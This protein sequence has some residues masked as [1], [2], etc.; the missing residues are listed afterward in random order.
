MAHEDAPWQ[1][2]NHS[3]TPNVRLSHPAVASADGPAPLI[4]V[5]AAIDLEPETPLTID[6]TLSEWDMQSSFICSESGREVRGF[7]HL[8]EAEQDASLK[9]A[10]PHIPKLVFAAFIRPVVA[11][12][13]RDGSCGG[14]ERAV[15][16]V[17]SLFH[18]TTNLFYDTAT[19]ATC[20]ATCAT[21][22]ALARSGWKPGGGTNLMYRPA[23]WIPFRAVDG[24]DREV[25][26]TRPHSRVVDRAQARPIF[27]GKDLF[28]ST[29]HPQ[30]HVVVADVAPL[31]T[32]AVT[33]IDEHMVPRLVAPSR[34]LVDPH[35]RNPLIAHAAC[36][37]D[38]PHDHAP[39]AKP[40]VLDAAAGCIVHVEAI[41]LPAHPWCKQTFTIEIASDLVR[42]TRASR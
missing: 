7:M 6:Y 21:C 22:A 41:Q 30:L 10:L 19:C 29:D 34:Q 37:I 14:R 17:R 20:A 28:F 32:R 1:F 5:T 24:Q 31:T 12:L 8:T 26:Y 2:L 35:L 36:V 40:L 4:S 33:N 38:I 13:E 9:F 11:M 27:R 18:F 16:G 3:F 39:V 23:P 42:S 25:L 15:R